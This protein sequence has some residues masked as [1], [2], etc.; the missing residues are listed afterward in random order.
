MQK[1]R[2]RTLI[3]GMLAVLVLGFATPSSPAFAAEIIRLKNGASVR[4]DKKW[5]LKSLGSQPFGASELKRPKNEAPDPPNIAQLDNDWQV[6]YIPLSLQEVPDGK[7][8]P[9]FAGPEPTTFKLKKSKATSHEKKLVSLGSMSFVGEFDEHGRRTVTIETPG[10]Q[11]HVIQSITDVGPD[12]VLVESADMEWKF[13]LALKTIPLETIDKIIRK[14]VPEDDANARFALALFY[15]QARYYPQAFQELNAIGRD[16]PGKMELVK[17][18]QTRFMDDFGREILQRLKF[19]QRSGQHQLAESFSKELLK[20]PLSVAVKQ[21]V[22]KHLRDYEES[23]Q[24]IERAKLLL[25]EWQAKLNDAEQEKH[26]QPLRSEVTEQLNFETLPRLDAFIKAE[27]DT[28]YDA[29]QRLGL[30]YTG[31]VLGAANAIPD[32]D[33][34][35]RIWD[36]RSA[37]LEYLRSDDPSRQ[38][39][40]M[41]RLLTAENISAEKVILNMIAQLP[42]ILDASD[43]DPAV[44]HQVVV[45]GTEPKSYWV[46]LPPEY[47]HH[48]NYPMVIALRHRTRSAQETLYHWAGD[49]HRPD[50][51][52][53]RGYIVIVPEYAEKGQAEYTFGA[54][55]HKYVLDCLVDARKRFSVDSDRVYLGGHGMGADAA[56]DIGMAHPDE[57]AGVVPYGGRAINYC[58]YSWN[59]ARYTSWYVIGTGYFGGWRDPK[60]NPVFDRMMKGN[61]FDFM[62]VEYIGR[63]GEDLVDETSKSFDWMDLV[64]HERKAQPKEFEVR[65]LRKTDNRFFWLT[66]NG[67]PYDVILPGPGEVNPMDIEVRVSPGNTKTNIINVKLPGQTE[68]WA[69]R[70][71]PQLVDFGKKVEVKVNSRQKFSGFVEPDVRVLLDDLQLRGDRKRL[72]LAVITP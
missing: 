28:E 70:L 21:E 55:A 68:N 48:H 57:F 4:A 3:A 65:S 9:T 23:R 49:V 69:L 15:I 54:P 27:A 66:A 42:P 53:Q 47:T 19:R 34:A 7:G 20:Q 30:A 5:L 58:H 26:L 33:Q 25:G 63:N 52:C 44:P 14:K 2:F 37:V 62:L 13:G 59:N 6:T 16:F 45:P 43:I 67:L 8:N 18:Y 40:L 1:H 22:Q 56:F 71:T 24:T 11:R 36:A 46:M 64:S 10:K 60:S 72:P 51:G 12:H 17:E 35:F 61:K 29:A 41:R 32:L 31:W 38:S 50:L 39:Q